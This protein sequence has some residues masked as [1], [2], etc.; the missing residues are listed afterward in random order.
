MKSW[1]LFIVVV[2]MFVLLDAI[3]LGLI[4]K[5]FYNQELGELARRN[6]GALAPRWGAAVLVYLLIPA[7]L[8]LFVRP[9]L[10]SQDA[11]PVAFAWGALFGL[12][13]YGV[14]DLTNFAV[15]DKWTL[16]MTV[17]DIAWGATICGGVSVFIW[18]LQKT[19]Q[20]EK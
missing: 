12:V 2:F 5:G 18:L 15:I 7:G 10:K 16:R 13:V 3:W 4:M 9:L 11:F 17:F 19:F 1:K 8:V 20:S 6:Q 14:Y